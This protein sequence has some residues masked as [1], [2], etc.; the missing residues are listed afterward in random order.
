MLER[1]AEAMVRHLDGALARIWTLNEAADVLEL[2]ASAGLDTHIDGAHGRVPVGRYKIG[3]IAQEGRPHLTNA[4]LTDP[5]GHDQEWARR[6]GLVA[7]AGY[8]LLVEE[9]L[10][11]VMALFARQP[12]S[13]AT[14]DSMASVAGGI[15]VGI[16]RLQA[17]EQLHRQEADRRVARAIQQGL[18]PK[19]M[20]RVA[21]L[22]IA[23][24]MATAE[25][26]GGDC[27]DFVPLPRQ[28]HERVGVV[29][30]D[31]S[32]HGIAAALLMAQTR[33]YL[34]AFALAGSDVGTL[35]V[36]TNR[37]LARDLVAGHFVTLLLVELDPRTRSLVH[38]SAGH[39]PGYVLD[40]QGQIKATLDSTGPPLGIDPTS[41]FPVAPALSLAPGDLVFAYTDG[42]PE[43]MSVAGRQFGLERALA[44][45]REHRHQTPEAILEALVQAVTAF[46]AS[47]VRLDDVTAVI[48]KAEDGA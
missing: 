38:A 8:P 6:E 27:F 21:G 46:S 20:P 18:V 1:C 7:F 35:L 26:V 40:R 31:A 44:V 37:L 13:E 19:A 23:G 17:D 24:R 15:A 11:G 29:V 34:R 32:G 43:A 39:C 16:K 2:R 48:I 22:R 42:I 10:V 30:G 5:G 12:L 25:H 14:L 28:G 47:H 36:S 3:L 41:E 33:A 4:V 45:V 9:H